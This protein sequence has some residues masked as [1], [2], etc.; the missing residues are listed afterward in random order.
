MA[1]RPAPTKYHWLRL[2]SV[3]HPTE[4]PER[5]VAAMRFVA[6]MDEGQFAAV[7]EDA[8]METHHGLVQHVYEAAL[9]RSREVRGLLDRIFALEGVPGRLQETLEARTDEDGVLYLRLDKQAAY[10]GELRLTDGEDAI[11]LRL[12]LETYPATRAAAM[13]GLEG[14]L[15]R[16]KA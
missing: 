13:A 15:R 10:L 1:E 4:E 14:M 7:L 16:G 2:R 8:P 3:A 9:E 11:Q 5:V 6:G 12:K